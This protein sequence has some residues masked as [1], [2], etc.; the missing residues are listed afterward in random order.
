MCYPASWLSLPS[1]LSRFASVF[2][3]KSISPTP[4]LLIPLPVSRLR[5]GH[6]APNKDLSVG[7]LCSCA[8]CSRRWCGAG[9]P[10]ELSA[11]GRQNVYVRAPRLPDATPGAGE[12]KSILLWGWKV[13][14]SSSSKAAVVEAYFFI[15]LVM[16]DAPSCVA[17]GKELPRV[18][19]SSCAYDKS[20]KK[21]FD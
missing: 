17:N 16:I 13:T 6:K 11:R 10:L 12:A 8:V 7:N 18:L 9:L 14:T 2:Q 20:P 19:A 3:A 21:G 5:S 1:I 4:L 15:V